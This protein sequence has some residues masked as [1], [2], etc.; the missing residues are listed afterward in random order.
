MCQT[1]NRIILNDLV[2][3][4]LR[5][6]NLL[7]VGRLVASLA[8]IM[9]D[10]RL[11]R[12]A[13]LVQLAPIYPVLLRGEIGERL[14]RQVLHRHYVLHVLI[15]AVGALGTKA[16]RVVL[17]DLL[18][19]TVPELALCS[20]QL[21]EAAFI[22]GTVLF[23]IRLSLN[24]M[25]EDTGVL[26][27][28]LTIFDEEGADWHFI[29]VKPMEV[30]TLL[31][32]HARVAI[33]MYAHLRFELSLISLLEEGGSYCFD[34]IDVDLG[35]AP[36]LILWMGKHGTTAHFHLVVLLKLHGLLV[37]MPTIPLHL[38]EALLIAIHLIHIVDLW[39]A[40][41][42]LTIAILVVWRR[43]LTV[44]EMWLQAL[45]AMLHVIV[46][47]HMMIITVDHYFDT[48]KFD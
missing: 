1:V 36:L 45:W 6:A 43:V 16:Q 33:P 9:T 4:L 46:R 19:R 5:D 38:T 8:A 17:T 24:W 47:V 13:T 22:V 28:T 23:C 39:R 2:Q 35:L 29:R 21:A 7:T 34:F 18:L 12:V 40:I 26:L 27:I 30:A 15:V 20:T 41:L 31:A 48:I 32:L 42:E 37:W 11:M 3:L 14:E 44:V 25:P 10:P